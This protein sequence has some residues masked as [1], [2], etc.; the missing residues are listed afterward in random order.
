MLGKVHENVREL[1]FELSLADG[2]MAIINYRVDGAGRL[3]LLHTQVPS[4]FSGRG[5]GSH[6]AQG[7]F[8]IVE[9]TCRQAVLRCPFLQMFFRHHPEYAGI[10]V[11]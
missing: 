7:T 8:E 6:L 4:E 10:V 2:E 9:E 1:R 5:V 3:V 11:G